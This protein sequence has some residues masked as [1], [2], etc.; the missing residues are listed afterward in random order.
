MCTHCRKHIQ[1][2]VLVLI[3]LFAMLDD[4]HADWVAGRDLANRSVDKPQRCLELR[5]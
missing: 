4:T 3:A 1:H 2:L 5:F